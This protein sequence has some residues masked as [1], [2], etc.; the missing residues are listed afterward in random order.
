LKGRIQRHLKKDKRCFWHIDYLLA[1]KHSSIKAIIYSKTN[2]RHEC[3]IVGE[4]ANMNV[5]PI[6]GFGVS[7]CEEGC[8]SHLHYI[9]DDSNGTIRGI[10]NVYNDL[11][12]EAN[13]YLLMT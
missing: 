5:K 10:L 6:K 8:K 11:G 3:K 2:I 4:I 9:I 1:S 13:L 7:D 12:L